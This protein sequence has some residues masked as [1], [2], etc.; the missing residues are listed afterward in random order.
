MDFLWLPD[1]A[2]CCGTSLQREKTYLV[3]QGTGSGSG[4]WRSSGLGHVFTTSLTASK[5]SM[6]VAPSVG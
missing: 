5:V 4:S 3:V 6:F 2:H 1:S